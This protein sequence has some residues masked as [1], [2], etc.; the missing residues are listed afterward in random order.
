MSNVLQR[1][2][3]F[4]KGSTTSAF[5]VSMLLGRQ[6]ESYICGKYSGKLEESTY[7]QNICHI[8]EKMTGET[9][10]V[11]SYKW[12]AKMVAIFVAFS[13]RGQ[14]LKNSQTKRL[15]SIYRCLLLKRS[16][17][18]QKIFRR[19]PRT[20]TEYARL[21]G[22]LGEEEREEEELVLTTSSS[23]LHLQ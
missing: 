23:L 10:E 17:R 4:K 5:H 1:E 21:T 15:P 19:L 3:T 2:L 7:T 16:N 6:A 20:A 12:K 11:R 9:V 13:L 22:R 14:P 18:P 8:G